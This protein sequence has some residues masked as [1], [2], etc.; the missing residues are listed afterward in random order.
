M[1]DYLL[2]AER[3]ESLYD[4]RRLSAK[5]V[6]R[7]GHNAFAASEDRDADNYENTRKARLTTNS[8][9]SSHGNASTTRRCSPKSGWPGRQP[10]QMIIEHLASK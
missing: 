4:Q 2:E 7:R 10:I 5:P 3:R 8:S 9:E 1:I 6:H